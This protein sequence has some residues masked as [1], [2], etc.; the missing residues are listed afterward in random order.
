MNVPF[1]IEQFLQ[2]FKNYN[3]AIWPMQFVF[4][5]FGFVMIYLAVQK[6]KK[7]D[8]IINVILAFLWFWMGFIYH[9]DFFTS[10]N[11]AAWVFGF[12]NIMQGFIFLYSGAF[13]SR[14]TFTY[15]SD[16]YGITGLL[17]LVYA[18]VVYPMIGY[19][20]GHAYPYSPTF[21]LPCPT[22]IFTLGMFLLVDRR[23]SL[24]ILAIPFLWSIVGT[25]AALNFGIKEDA[26]LLISGITA[27]ALIVHR[28]RKL[29]PLA[30][31]R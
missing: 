31:P 10:I 28:N 25:S 30:E 3:L 5:V 20:S 29:Y 1:T 27:F 21:G 2:V 16:I 15:H 14:I 12:L 4:Y 8:I 6:S 11:K 7:P 24:W 22:T 9:F 13:K 18:L 17:I 26:G 23:V 19:F